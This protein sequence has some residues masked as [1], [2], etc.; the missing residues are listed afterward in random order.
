MQSN[1]FFSDGNMT[2]FNYCCSGKSTNQSYEIDGKQCIPC[3][4][5]TC[6]DILYSD[7]FLRE[8]F[9]EVTSKVLTNCISLTASYVLE[10][11]FER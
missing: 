11:N 5:Y 9:F 4:C 10:R 3:E 6:R 7:T 1:T 2:E 8:K